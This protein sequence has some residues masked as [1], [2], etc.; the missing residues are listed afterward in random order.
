MPQAAAPKKTSL[1][2]PIKPKLAER[3]CVVTP[4]IGS[5]WKGLLLRPEDTPMGEAFGNAADPDKWVIVRCT[6]RGDIKGLNKALKVGKDYLVLR[7]FVD[8][9]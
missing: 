4:A 2:R 8:M 1:K 5:Q 7:A 3:R 6:D 9:V